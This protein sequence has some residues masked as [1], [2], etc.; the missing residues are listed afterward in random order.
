MEEILKQSVH[1]ASGNVSTSRTRK[2]EE[3]RRLLVDCQGY[4][5]EPHFIAFFRCFNSGRFFEAH[6]V[7]EAL[8]LQDRQGMIAD[9][10]KGLIQLAGA[11]VHLQ[12]NRLPPGMALFNLARKNLEKYPRTTLNWPVESGLALIAEWL[13]CLHP[14]NSRGNPLLYLSP[15]QLPMP[16]SDSV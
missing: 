12:K 13:G 1:D 15:P 4:G 11:M 5:V 7:L 8:W 10:Y 14:D 16:Q 9:F 3:I 2:G 6:E